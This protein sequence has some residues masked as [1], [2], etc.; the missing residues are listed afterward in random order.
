MV[1]SNS[2][3]GGSSDNSSSSIYGGSAAHFLVCSAM[4]VL[5][6]LCKLRPLL[7]PMP[8]LYRHVNA[9]RQITVTLTADICSC[10]TP[11]TTSPSGNCH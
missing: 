6:L 5:L 9:T 4:L 3:S 2:D 10:H 11:Q 7:S 1:S 8:W